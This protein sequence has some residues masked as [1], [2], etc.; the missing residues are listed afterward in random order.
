LVTPLALAATAALVAACS[1]GSTTSPLLRGAPTLSLSF[2]TAQPKSPS[3]SGARLVPHADIQVGGAAGAPRTVTISGVQMVVAN[4]RLRIQGGTC[5]PGAGDSTRCSYISRT[6]MVVALPV[7]GSLTTVLS[8]TVPAATYSGMHLE[9]AAIRNHS[10]DHGEAGTSSEAAAR[11]AFLAA[12]PTFAGVSVK[13]TGT[14]VDS[15]GTAHPFTYNA[16]DDADL[17]LDFPSPI[18]V[19][20]TRKLPNLTIAV[21]IARFFVDPHGAVLDPTDSLNRGRIMANIEHAFHG[22][23]DDNRTGRDDHGEATAGGD[24]QA[25]DHPDGAAPDTTGASASDTTHHG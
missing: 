7:D 9:I 14:Y 23:R 24:S 2:G 15:A 21:D 16:S 19:D 25:D 3:G 12:N 6:P 8:D 18:T 10:G 13:V 20:S 1:A 4:M 5:T 22:F 11:A 17:R